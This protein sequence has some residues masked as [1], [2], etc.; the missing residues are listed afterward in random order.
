M[1][2]IYKRGKEIVVDVLQV[3]EATI[4]KG[5][6]LRLGVAAPKVSK[7]RYIGRFLEWEKCFELPIESLLYFEAM[8]REFY[9]HDG[10]GYGPGNKLY[11][12]AVSRGLKIA[13][14]LSP[15]TPFERETRRYFRRNSSRLSLFSRIW[16]KFVG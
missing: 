5:G 1:L 16:T 3:N 9:V 8:A 15:E 12:A 6:K 11:A 7:Q 4:T 13:R 14:K 2:A 10:D